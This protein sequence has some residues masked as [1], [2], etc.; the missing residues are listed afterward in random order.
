MKRASTADEQSGPP[1]RKKSKLKAST[2]QEDSEDEMD[3]NV[4]HSAL[5]PSQVNTQ[6]ELEAT[7]K[8][9]IMVVSS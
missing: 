7:T 4:S 6:D 9:E 1:P 5:I 8:G 2:I 3:V